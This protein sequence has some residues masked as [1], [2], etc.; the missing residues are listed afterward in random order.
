M[1]ASRCESEGPGS[2]SSGHRDIGIP[3]N[4][5]DESGIIS[6]SSIELRMPLEVLKGGQASCQDEAGS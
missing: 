6:F 5:Q 2:L 4:F 3:I 1:E